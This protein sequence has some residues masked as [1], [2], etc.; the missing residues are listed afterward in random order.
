MLNFKEKIVDDAA[1][2]GDA[3]IVEESFDD[4]EAVP[5]VHFVEAAA[6]DDVGVGEIEQSGRLDL[7]GVDLSEVGDGD[8]QAQDAHVTAV[9][10][11]GNVSGH[12]EIMRQVKNGDRVKLGVCD[13]V[14]VAHG[15]GEGVPGVADVGVDGLRRRGRFVLR[16]GLGEGEGRSEGNRECESNGS[17]AKCAEANGH[18]IPVRLG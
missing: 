17:E 11:G 1:G 6:G 2:E 14:A 4:E 3:V 7:R 9:L 15:A 13:G 16:R 12:G 10:H 5:A 8:R 18:R